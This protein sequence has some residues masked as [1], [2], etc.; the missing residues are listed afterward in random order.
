[1]V[2]S[3]VRLGCFGTW[4]GPV[5]EP[6]ADPLTRDMSNQEPEGIN[7]LYALGY[8][9]TEEPTSPSQA[10]RAVRQLEELGRSATIGTKDRRPVAKTDPTTPQFG[11]R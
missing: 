10:T 3:Q 4:T 5:V 2:Q 6:S 11:G 8:S 9:P 1:M 7:L